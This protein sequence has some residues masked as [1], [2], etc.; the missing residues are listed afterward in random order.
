MTIRIGFKISSENYKTAGG[1]A[2]ATTHIDNLQ[3]IAIRNKP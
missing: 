1:T 2:C 3:A